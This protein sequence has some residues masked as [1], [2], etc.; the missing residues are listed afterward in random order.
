MVLQWLQNQQCTSIPGFSLDLVAVSKRL[1]DRRLPL[2][3]GI[4]MGVILHLPP[5]CRPPRAPSS[6]IQRHAF[7]IEQIDI[8]ILVIMLLDFSACEIFER[9]SAHA[10]TGFFEFER[11]L[12]FRVCRKTK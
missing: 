2:S 1:L 12:D 8:I 7:D 5:F 10:C 4:L 6:G 3:M 11:L 9:V